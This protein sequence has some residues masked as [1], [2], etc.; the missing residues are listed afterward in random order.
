MDKSQYR[1]LVVD[2]FPTMRRIV[3][4]LLKS[5]VSPTST[6]PRTVPPAWPRSRKAGSIL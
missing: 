4:N 2:D 6:R 1:F 5:S 3:R